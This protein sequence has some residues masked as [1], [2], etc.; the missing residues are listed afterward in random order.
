MLKLEFNADPTYIRVFLIAFLLM[1]ELILVK[2]IEILGSGRQ[3][4]ELEI[5]YLL[6][7]G[8]LQLIT[9]ILTFLRK[10]EES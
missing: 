9:Y 8:L 3:P 10:T 6:A 5:E 4:T 1:L 7:L 2:L